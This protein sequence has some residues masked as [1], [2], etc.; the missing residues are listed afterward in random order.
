MEEIYDFAIDTTKLESLIS[1]M[2]SER[3]NMDNAVK[4]IY[5]TLDEIG[6]YWEG[7]TYNKAAQSLTRY[8]KPLESSIELIDEIIKLLNENNEQSTGVINKITGMV[9]EE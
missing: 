8:Q 1:T 3:D 2:K 6:S 4:N 5:K 7:E 9:S